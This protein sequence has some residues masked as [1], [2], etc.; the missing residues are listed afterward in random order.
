MADEIKAGRHALF[1]GFAE[2][3]QLIWIFLPAV[4]VFHLV[5]LA[6]LTWQSGKG[7]QLREYVCG[8]PDRRSKFTVGS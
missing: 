8:T 4:V 5:G 3:K 6:I 1:S 7:C 2:D